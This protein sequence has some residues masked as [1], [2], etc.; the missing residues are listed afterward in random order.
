[1]K[2]FITFAALF[3]FAMTAPIWL[4]TLLTPIS[5]AVFITFIVM[6]IKACRS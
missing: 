6:T 3:V 4:I 1:M 5:L 2:L